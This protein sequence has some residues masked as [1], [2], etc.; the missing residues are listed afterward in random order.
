MEECSQAVYGQLTWHWCGNMSPIPRSGRLQGAPD[1]WTP[2]QG[3]QVNLSSLSVLSFYLFFF[4]MKE[5]ENL[6]KVCKKERMKI[7]KQI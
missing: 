1:T 5:S 6:V 7:E 2:G 4:S 3:D